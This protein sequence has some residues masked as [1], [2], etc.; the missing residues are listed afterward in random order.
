MKIAAV[1]AHIAIRRR[2][3]CILQLQ[4]CS[5]E[6]WQNLFC[7]FHSAMEEEVGVP[8]IQSSGAKKKTTVLE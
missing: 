5:Y 8:I 4:A 3:K 2:V 6:S 7:V 1:F